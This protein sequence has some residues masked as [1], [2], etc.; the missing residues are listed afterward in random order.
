MGVD[1]VLETDGHLAVDVA[2]DVRDVMRARG[3]LRLGT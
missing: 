1:T 3:L 2:A